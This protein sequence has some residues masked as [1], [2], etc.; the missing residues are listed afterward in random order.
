M[1]IEKNRKQAAL[2]NLIKMVNKS[3]IA[4]IPY[5]ERL[6]SNFTDALE[7]AELVLNSDLEKITLYEIQNSQYELQRALEGLE[8]SHTFS[9]KSHFKSIY[10]L[11]NSVNLRRNKRRQR[12]YLKSIFLTLLILCTI[13]RM[14]KEN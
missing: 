5:T 12:L 8:E 4:D 2:N 7:N 1:K 6:F 13:S 3:E 10:Y 11:K 14:K 9:S